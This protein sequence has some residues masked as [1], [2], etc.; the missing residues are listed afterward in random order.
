MRKLLFTVASL[1]AFLLITGATWYYSRFREPLLTVQPLNSAKDSAA[2]RKLVTFS[3][4]LSEYAAL[5]KYNTRTGFLVD[6]S[7]PSGENR[8]FIMNLEKDSVID[9][10]L[11]TH[12]RC[13]ED[14][15]N[16][17]KYSN[18]PGS[19]CTSLGRYKIGA[20]YQGRFGLAYKLHGLD[21]SNSNAFRRY[22]VLHSHN[23]VPDKETQP[24]PICQSDGCPTVS[25]SFLKKL[26]QIMDA[27]EKPVV[28]WIYE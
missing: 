25:P 21:S 14:W 26:Q 15:L 3:A 28:L 17:R 19:G 1:T 6:M 13:N 23:C 8:F 10:G 5:K 2:F 24:F 11:V 20:S 9:A 7:L 22:V 12:G 18:K 27:S 4:G 16:G